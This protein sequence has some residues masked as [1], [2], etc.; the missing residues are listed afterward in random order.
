MQHF[1]SLRCQL[2]LAVALTL[3]LLANAEVSTDQPV[4]IYVMVG[5]S[6]MQ[7]KG[8]I[9]GEE[10][11]SLRHMVEND[12]EEEFQF[13][14]DED[15]EWR[16]RSDVWIH[17]D[18]GPGN[19]KYGGLEPGYGSHGGVVGPELGFGHVI[20]DASEGQVLL[21]KAC[22]GGKS[23]GHNFLPPSVGKYPKPVERSDPGFY[24]HEILRI[25]EDVTENI[26]TYFPDYYGQ[27]IEIAGLGFHQGWND[28]YG[29]LD[30][31]YEANLATF[32]HDIRSVEHGLGV[33][34]LP[35]VIATSGM[36]EKESLIKQGQLA[37][38]DPNKYPQ[39]A[40]N[41]GVVDTEKPYGSRKIEFK[42]YTEKSPDKVGYHWN[43]HARSY[44]NIGRA[45]AAEMQTLDR[46]TPPSRLAA[47]GVPEGVRLTWQLGSE[48]PTSINLLRN[49]ENLEAEL[50]ASQTTYVDTTALP[51]EHRYELVLNLPSS[52]TQKLDA[53]CDTSVSKLKAYRGIEGVVLSW[54][55]RGRF[56]GFWIQ[57]DGN[58]I[59]D[60]VAGDLRSFVDKQAPSKGAVEYTIEPTTGKT[61]AAS[62]TVNLGLAD[63]G[64]AVVYEPFD[65]PAAADEPQSL[66]G[67]GGA[68]GTQGE[69]YYLSDEKLDRAPAAIGRGLS[70]GSLAATGNR[71]SSHRWSPGCAIALDDSLRNS[72]LLEDGA[73]LWISYVFFVT[74]EIEHRQGGGTVMLY[75]DDLQQG[76]GF[77]TNPGEYRTAVVVDG[78]LKAVRIAS[79]PKETPSLVVGKIVWGTDGE[80]DSFVP[81]MPGR[82]LK[83][84]EKHGRASAPFNIDQAKLS[85]LVLQGE[86]QFD[87]IRVGPT[88]ESVIGGRT[89]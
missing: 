59:A 42:F 47:V 68:V 30:A 14:I 22:W 65:Y 12:P 40:G 41:V 58:V 63:P 66:L 46:P 88:Y 85:L 87:E 79:S 18:S 61:T 72:G 60:G 20:G 70:Y 13:L 11:N 57:R 81:Y 83:Q 25:V 39:F 45:M 43:N 9:E 77:Q 10:S 36:I 23:L 75:T 1:T 34:D 67:K 7:G 80:D 62:L 24:Y 29:G 89:K 53:L 64:D 51:G 78:N 86:G 48:I 32:I 4:K 54:E 16:E 55:A 44:V 38:G 6:N 33:P 31:S 73:T 8:S 17:L 71:A 84:P 69:Y 19:I 56:D 28:Q 37:M 15:G 76:V 35:V 50:S 74:Q 82:D 3:A 21:I 2:F 49:D 52:E 26:E 27:G 5:Q